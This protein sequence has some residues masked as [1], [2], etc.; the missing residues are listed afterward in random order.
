M[1]SASSSSSATARARPCTGPVRAIRMNVR[2]TWRNPRPWPVAGAS[3]TTTSCRPASRSWRILP[4]VTSSRRPGGGRGEVAEDAV[5]EHPLVHRTDLHL[6]EQVLFERLLGVDRQRVQPRVDGRHVVADRVALVEEAG[7]P[8]LRRDL[9][10]ER[11]PAAPG[12]RHPE[13]G[14][15]GRLAHAPLS[16][17]DQ[18]TP[19]EQRHAARVNLRQDEARAYNRIRR[20]IG[21]ASSAVGLAALVAITAAAGSL[22]TYGC[23]VALAIGLPLLEL[24]FAVAGYRLSR[25]YGLSRQSPGGWLADRAKGLAVGAVL[26]IAVAGGLLLI[27]RARGRPVA[28][29]GMGRRRGARRPARRALPGPAPAALPEERADGR[30]RPRR[31]DVGHGPRG[32]A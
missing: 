16:G 19:V 12:G 27:Q 23:I 25:R 24:P 4:R 21:Y 2:G 1:R 14:R 18:E 13:G 15:D 8:L 5:L 28:A 10:E 6:T 9:D 17:H 31:C 3:T 11:A 7:H 22:G 26:G 32:R 29:S 20:R 30:G